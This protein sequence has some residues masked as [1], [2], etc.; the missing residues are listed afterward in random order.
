M[1]HPIEHAMNDLR[2]EI[3]GCDDP[4]AVRELLH[5]VP[6]LQALCNG[7]LDQLEP[8]R[9]YRVQ[10]R[11]VMPVEARNE[12]EAEELAADSI[13]FNVPEGVLNEIEFLGGTVVPDDFEADA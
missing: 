3:S 13:T 2:D 7:R 12:E 9:A 4:E 5:D 1:A 6:N 11:I 8:R 10:V